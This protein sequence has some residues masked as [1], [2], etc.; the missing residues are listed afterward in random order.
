MHIFID[1]NILLDFFHFSNDQLKELTNLLN[2]SVVG[3][4]RIYL[5]Q[6]VHDE[7]SR[8]RER[9]LHDAMKRFTDCKVKSAI[10]AFMRERPESKKMMKLEGELKQLKKQMQ[11]Q[12]VEDIKGRHLQADHVMADLMRRLDVIPVTKEDH[13]E[14]L[15]RSQVGNPPG[16][17][18]SIG[19]AINWT[20]L[21]KEVPSGESLH[22]VSKDGDFFS[23][24]ND[25]EAMEFL[26]EEWRQSKSAGLFVY[27]SLAS[28]MI[29]NDL[30][31]DGFEQLVL[32]D[33]LY[34]LGND[35]VNCDE[36]ICGLIAE[37]NSCGFSCDEAEVL[38][39]RKT[40]PDAI[41]FEA[42]LTITADE[43]RKD[44]LPWRGDQIRVE[45]AGGYVRDSETGWKIEDVSI[46]SA[47]L[48]D[49]KFLEP[50][51]DAFGLF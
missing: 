5:T 41:S 8:N 38:Q 19:D 30:Y 47:D 39:A 45:L 40:D 33:D 42:Y 14:A 50:D 1:T 4:S 48:N 12:V 15:R 31:F 24:L 51:A 9:K 16:K 32:T 10:P 26:A 18:R 27:R 43:Q 46:V 25:D 23:P 20:L 3:A 7:F 28:F 36:T 13:D 17:P 2:T 35:F 49:D 37:S 29:K 6:Q 44:G 21:L 34:E 11:S 22:V